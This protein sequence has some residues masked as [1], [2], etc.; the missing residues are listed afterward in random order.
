MNV[1]AMSRTLF[2][3]GLSTIESSRLVPL[4]SAAG[5][6]LVAAT[7][8]AS[9]VAAFGGDVIRVAVR[10]IGS[11]A[12]RRCRLSA[13]DGHQLRRRGPATRLGLNDGSPP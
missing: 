9:A 6:A 4:R 11:R 5:T 7:V 1:H 2:A 13:M 10:A 12:E 3:H 8:L